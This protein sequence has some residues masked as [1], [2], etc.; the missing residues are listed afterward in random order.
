PLGLIR[1]TVTLA[2]VV[3]EVVD[4]CRHT[5]LPL[6]KL[7][8]CCKVTVGDGVTSYGMYKTIQDGV[9]ALPASGGTVC[10]LPG[11]YNESVLIKGRHDIVIHGCDARSRV[12]AVSEQNGALPAF[13][14]VDSEDIGLERLGIEAGP[15]SAVEILHS[16]RVAVRACV[17]Q[18]RDLPTI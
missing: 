14:I 1:W 3:G 11:V 5:F 2:G 18:M 7:R 4:D 17:I 8:G 16:Q 15:R 13:L 10:V 6:T 9:T 12:Q